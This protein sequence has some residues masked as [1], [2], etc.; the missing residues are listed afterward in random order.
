LLL[1]RK[2]FWLSL[3][4]PV[5]HARPSIDVCFESAASA[6][7]AGTLC[8]LLT[9]GSEDGAAGARAVKRAGGCVYVQ[10]P[11]TAEAPAGPR[12]LLAKTP[13][14][15]VLDLPQIASRIGALPR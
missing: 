1:D 3:E 4:P 13:V 7:G 11:E 12:A 5:W 15:A 2:A 6:F 10:D 14:D 9:C 8:V